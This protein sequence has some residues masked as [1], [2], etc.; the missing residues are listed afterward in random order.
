[1]PAV[2]AYD[3]TA[4]FRWTD[5]QRCNHNRSGAGHPRTHPQAA[6][7]LDGWKN[8]VPM[9]PGVLRNGR[10]GGTIG[11]LFRRRLSMFPGQSARRW[12]SRPGAGRDS[13]LFLLDGRRIRNPAS[14]SRHSSWT[15][16]HCAIS[17]V[18][19]ARRSDRPEISNASRRF[20]CRSYSV[21][22]S[23]RRLALAQT[24][25]RKGIARHS[26]A[27]NRAPSGGPRIEK[28]T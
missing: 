26:H 16:G 18:R 8:L 15:I 1:M 20:N 12:R 4:G 10:S 23:F 28:M 3:S 19:K 13:Q 24:F 21:A 9:V 17:S 7:C 5:C 14:A 22:P 25:A 2:S 6:F 27:Q 11:N